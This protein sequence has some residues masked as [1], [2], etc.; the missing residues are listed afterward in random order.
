MRAI[1]LL[2]GAVVIIAAAVVG[3]IKIER[4]APSVEFVAKPKA[5]GRHAEL[6]LVARAPE[7][8]GLRHVDVRLVSGGKTYQ[9][10]EQDVPAA[11]WAGS[12]V[13]EQPIHVSADLGALGVAEG[14]AQLQVSADTYGW[15]ILPQRRGPV[16]EEAIEIDLT[17]PTAQLLT[18]QHNIRVGG[19]GAAVVRLSP[20]TAEAHIQVGDYSFP[21]IRG[22]FADPDVGLALFAV[23]QDLTTGARPELRVADAVGNT[24]T[25]ALPCA[26]RDNHFP[27]RDLK[28]DDSFLARKVPE[29]LANNRQPPVQDLVQGY[30]F[31]NRDLRRQTEARV[32]Q[33]TATSVPHPLWDGAFHR[34][35]NSA[36][37]SSFAD[38]RVYKY[39]DQVIDRQTHLGFDLAS[40]QRAPVEAA[41]N[42]I[43]VFAG[44]LGIYGNAVIIDHGLGVFSLYGHL[45]SIVV[46]SGQAVKMGEHIGQTGD[47]GLAGGDH[48]H[49]SIML[50]GTHINPVEWWDGKWIRDHI[51]PALTILPVAAPPAPAEGGATGA[52]TAAAPVPDAAEPVDEQ[53]QPR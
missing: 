25:V 19:A 20:D 24:Q 51:T 52:A 45:S 6:D 10:F 12:G 23:P 15:H 18:T 9:L 26:I 2:L 28:L 5:V 34:Q 47:T 4:R 8:P 42:G 21:I 37:M 29:I 49:F 22:Y 39:G 46:K 43:V 33:I 13:T 16:S 32:K 7:S 35:S 50:D 17:P 41:Q 53:A 11:G 30:L 36:P 40:L 1:V 38:R 14:P 3:W 44:D 31:I 48:L 27:E